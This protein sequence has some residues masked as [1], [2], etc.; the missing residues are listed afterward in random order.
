VG[1]RTQPKH[2]DWT[3]VDRLDAAVTE[4]RGNGGTFPSQADMSDAKACE[5]PAEGRVQTR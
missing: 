3:Q 5:E 2:D 1:L 4:L